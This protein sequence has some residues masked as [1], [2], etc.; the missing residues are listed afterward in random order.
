MALLELFNNLSLIL[1]RG[2]IDNDDFHLA[3]DGLRF[4]IFEAAA[5]E[6]FGLVSGNDCRHPGRT[7]RRWRETDVDFTTHFYHQKRMLRFASKENAGLV[8]K[9]VFSGEPVKRCTATRGT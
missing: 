3:C 9:Q 5:D 4:Q 2:T 8:K 7:C 1:R 6:T